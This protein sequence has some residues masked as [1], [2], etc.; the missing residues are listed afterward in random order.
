MKKLRILLISSDLW[1]DISNGNNIQSNWFNGFNAEIANIYLVPGKPNNQICTRYFQ[2]TDAMMAKSFF[3]KRAG[4]SFTWSLKADNESKDATI[5]VEPENMGL[6]KKLRAHTGEWL[7]LAR[8]FLW[9]YGRYDKKALKAFINDFQPDIVFC[10]HLFSIKSRRIERVIHKMTDAPMIAFSGDA[11]ASLNVISDNPLFW[12]RR[13]RDH[14][15]YPA[16][17]K[18]FSYYFTFSPRWCDMLT[19][20]YGVPSEPLYKCVDGT[21]FEEKPVNDVI[22]LVYAGSLYCNRWKTLSVIGDAM[23]TINKD[24]QKI[25]MYVYSQSSLNEEQ[26]SALSEDKF[27]HFMGCVSPTE[28]PSIYNEAD[29]A[30]HV[31]SFDKKYMLETEHSFSTKLI[32]LMA[33][34]C[35]ILAICWN[36][37]SGWNYVKENDAAIC[38]SSYEEILLK[39]QEIVANPS[40]IQEYARKAAECGIK[41][42]NRAKIQKQIRDVFERVIAQAKVY[43]ENN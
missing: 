7:R 41:N 1:D 5:G 29:I 40:I 23:K 42:H 13:L 8:D 3:G 16:F 10:P 4:H 30:L 22:R 36:Q 39:L 25:E 35:A 33:S 11:E 17:V 27:I 38:L 19:K 24:G 43:K 9:A 12:C 32:D 31:E 14:L 21:P 6:Y 34:S 37:N 20:K 2:V 26:K 15:L 18:K 28:L